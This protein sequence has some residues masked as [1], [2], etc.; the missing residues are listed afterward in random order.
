VTGDTVNTAARLRSLAADD[1]IVVGAETWREV[2]TLVD[3]EA[4]DAVSVKGTQQPVIPYRIRGERGHADA[5]RAFIGHTEELI[6]FDAMLRVC[7][8]SGHGRLIVV[9]GDPGIGKTR[10]LGEVQVRAAASG[11]ACDR[12]P[13]PDFGTDTGRYAVRGLVRRSVG[14]GLD[15]AETQGRAGA[16]R[17]CAEGLAAADNEM[18]VCELLDV[19]PPPAQ[20]AIYAALSREARSRGVRQ[21]LADPVRHASG[22]HPLPLL[23]E[24]VH[25]A[26]AW[27][28]DRL[29]SIAV[30]APAHPRLPVVATRWYAS[31][32]CAR[33]ATRCAWSNC[34]STPTRRGR[35]VFRHRFGRWCMRGSTGSTRLTSGRCRPPRCWV[36]AS[37]SMRCAI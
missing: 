35:R 14:L 29:A 24:D 2:S 3:A 37:R 31:A 23:V 10:L 16:Q 27:T 6:Q 5:G 30:L 12:A 7:R 15:A 28:L 17:A 32:C 20:R 22:H 34:C 4:G 36:S 18:F 19:A 8:E 13:V 9:R 21:T 26:D 25:W 33:R 11:F 1:E